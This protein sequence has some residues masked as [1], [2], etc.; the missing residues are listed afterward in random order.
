MYQN[1]TRIFVCL[2]P[3]ARHA[4]GWNPV[5]ISYVS[6]CYSI[7]LFCANFLV[8]HL[9]MKGVSDFSM[10]VAGNLG[11][12]IFGS[13]VYFVWTEGAAT[14]AFVLPAV[15][16]VFS[17][18]W[19]GPANRSKYTAA[20]HDQSE[21][22]GSHG[23]MQAFLTQAMAIASFLAP[24]IVSTFV[25]RSPEDIEAGSDKHELTIGALFGPFCSAMCV[26]GLF[27][28][29]YCARKGKQ[30]EIDEDPSSLSETSPLVG[31]NK[32]RTSLVEC[33]DTMSR[34][35]EV[36]RRLSA[37]IMGI[38]DPFD[39]KEEMTLREK[40]LKDMEEWEQI[41]KEAVS[42]MALE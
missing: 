26:V 39:N 27:Y 20:V 1:H 30:N 10:L 38:V 29:K 23:I 7:G 16:E 40:I 34:E 17:Y 24:T 25:L 11:F 35:S 13:A 8:L 9:S 33:T 42:T 22:A 5:Q 15:L 21:L 41:N 14:W 6:A 3:V 19:I 31:P 12:V 32:R 18:P 2:A 37:E 28:Q 4:L 36:N